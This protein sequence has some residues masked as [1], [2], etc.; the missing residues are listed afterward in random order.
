MTAPRPYTLVAELTY[1]CPLRCPYCSNPIN[2]QLKK[3]ELG[4]EQW[5]QVFSDA[6]E[7]GVVQ[8]HLSG[9]RGNRLL[10]PL[11]QR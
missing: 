6:A 3:G 10:G 2:L 8:L 4:T 7:L 5:C 9:G 11:D 1:R